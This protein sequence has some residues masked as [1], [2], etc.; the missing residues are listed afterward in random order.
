MKEVDV[1]S[2]VKSPEGIPLCP[3]CDNPMFTYEEVCIIHAHGIKALA[4]S[5]CIG[6]CPEVE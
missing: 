3:L 5:K 4:H 2:G 6:D 1:S